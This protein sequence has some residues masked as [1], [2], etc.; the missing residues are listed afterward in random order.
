MYKV[1]KLNLWLKNS[2]HNLNAAIILLQNGKKCLH[3]V[4]KLLTKTLYHLVH[5]MTQEITQTLQIKELARNPH[6]HTIQ[7]SWSKIKH[8]K[9]SR[10]RKMPKWNWRIKSWTMPA[11]VILILMFPQAFKKCRLNFKTFLE[12]SHMDCGCCVACLTSSPA[13]CAWTVLKEGKKIINLWL[14]LLHKIPSYSF[15]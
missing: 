10:R 2:S 12:P 11:L 5:I 4:Q 3:C 9:A 6:K 8:R 14:L 15:M 7:E 1:S 13:P